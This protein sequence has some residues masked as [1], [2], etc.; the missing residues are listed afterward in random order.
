[1]LAATAGGEGREV[2]WE[3]SCW[4]RATISART[5]SGREDDE[6]NAHV[7]RV[8]MVEDVRSRS[9]DL[10]PKCEFRREISRT[11]I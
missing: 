10:A 2:R 5:L 9:A 1:M 11:P 7:E 8:E 4:Y 3:E 6:G